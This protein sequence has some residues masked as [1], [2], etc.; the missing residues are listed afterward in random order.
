MAP[1]SPFLPGIV[2]TICGRARA[3]TIARVAAATDSFHRASLCAL[4]RI[5]RPWIP[6]SLLAPAVSGAHSRRR[7]FS[8]PVTFWAFLSQMLSPNTPCR[9]ALD[10]VIAWCALKD[11]RLPSTNTAAYCTARLALPL[12][13]LHAVNISVADTM[14]KR[15]PADDLWH[16]RRVV[17][18]D[19]TG[20]SMPDTPANQKKYPQPSGQKKGCGFP[21]VKIVAFFSLASG[22]LLAW[23]E[24]TWRQHDS[25]LWRVLWR[26]LLPGDIALGDRAFC[27]FASIA[28]LRAIK[29]DS[30]FRLH[31]G[32]SLP[33]FARGSHE[34][35]VTWLRPKRSK[36]W[37]AKLWET[38][39]DTIVVRI[40]KVTLSIPGFRTQHVLL[41]TSLLD[42][43]EYPAKDIA[44][45]YRRRWAVELFFRDIKTSMR[46]D[47]LTGMTPAMIQR[48]IAMFAIAYNLLRAL[49]QDAANAYRADLSRISFKGTADRLHEW[50]ASCAQDLLRPS[51]FPKLYADLI[52][53][54]ARDLVPL[55]PDRSEPRALKRRPKPYSFLT[56][57]RHKMRVPPH[58]GRPNRQ[59][60]RSPLAA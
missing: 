30:V 32:R 2:T 56:K 34:C 10:K 25:L 33:T 19:G 7:V 38:L 6:N 27:S 4:A 11:R 20:L 28:F 51:R 37:T 23:T 43:K 14:E 13:K 57:P 31:Q 46:M 48:Q 50:C 35:L 40:V 53:L 59:K 54:I 15:V 39:P 55:R 41:A 58:R 5:F 8:F 26:I 29:V 49:M 24:G 36:S 52:F 22:A 44:D 42:T 12:G 60:P 1:A 16:G 47:V 17:G 21:V 9:A 18:A 3:K 45:L